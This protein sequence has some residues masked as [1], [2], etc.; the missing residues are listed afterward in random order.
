MANISCDKLFWNECLYLSI[1]LYLIPQHVHKEELIDA[2]YDVLLS[3][4]TS[5]HSLADDTCIY[6]CIEA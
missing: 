2:S 6:N 4:I 5:F 3:I 1:L